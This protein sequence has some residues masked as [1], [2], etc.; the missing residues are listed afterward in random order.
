MNGSVQESCKSVNKLYKSVLDSIYMFDIAYKF[1]ITKYK[2][3][4]L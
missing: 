3:L 4:F 1:K 2:F